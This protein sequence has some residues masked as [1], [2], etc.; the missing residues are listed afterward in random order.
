MAM[1]LTSPVSSGN[2]AP[3]R[4]R[5]SLAVAGL[6]F[7][8][9]A[10]FRMGAQGGDFIRGD[11]NG[12]GAVDIGD[13]IALLGFLF[14]N[15]EAADCL[16]ALDANDSGEVDIAD[17]VS[18]LGYLF[19]D[20]APPPPP[21]PLRCGPDP[22]DDALACASHAACPAA[23]P[24][25]V[26][27]SAQSAGTPAAW[28]PH[29]AQAGV[30]WARL[31]P[32][33]GNIQPS[34]G[35][36]D[37][38]SVDA[39]L[40]TAA[41]NN[42]T[43]SGLFFYNV[44][45]LAADTHTFPM[46]NLDAWSTYVSRLVSHAGKSVTYWEVWNEPQGF[47]AGGTFADYAQVVIRAYDA[48]KAAD[49]AV[50]IGLS[51]AA[52]DVNYLQQTIKTGAAGHFDFVAVHP[53]E[54]T[55][56]LEKGWEPVFMSIV[57]GV[58]RMLAA[59]DTPRADVPVWFTELGRS[60]A[61][62]AEA[63]ARQ[64]HALVKAF[65]MAVAQGVTRV[66]WYEARDGQGG[67]GLL[68]GTGVR[69]AAYTALSSLTAHLGSVPD[70]R[71]WVQLNAGRDYGF[72]FQGPGTAV[73]PLW[74]A[75]GTTENVTFGAAVRVLDPATGGVT[76]LSA[77]SPLALTNAPVLILDVPSSLVARA[78]DNRS[79]AFPWGG[80]YTGAASIS[81]VMGDPNTEQG[82]H[83]LD[84][85][86]S[87]TPVE[88][89]GAAARDASKSSSQQFT[90]D[91]NFLCYTP[92]RIEITAVTRR[93]AAND[94]AGFN[95]KYESQTGWKTA[96][97]WYTVPGNTEWYTHTWTITD[98]QFVSIWGYNFRFDSDS[99]AHSRYY[100][101]QVTVTKAGGSR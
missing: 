75:A 9:A 67:F 23:S 100:I 87:S 18:M 99:T 5:R 6:V 47:A 44:R 7:A 77:G 53:Y 2:P 59:N 20:G 63:D 81:V 27:S 79:R 89:Y 38:A 85:D 35:T 83:Q 69:R 42:I 73:M 93:N 19:A 48:A 78:Q 25:G 32:E 4:R 62:S 29:M 36:W 86:S 49:P 58:R 71:G 34:A 91:P 24:F 84:P 94:N 70:F 22:T 50:Q 95:L 54:I 10:A 30:A 40:G 65:T 98:D 16:D 52:N 3:K 46:S 15:V 13:P 64:A 45:W 11:A 76:N 55:E 31:F 68:S 21:G 80:D 17:A 12:D 60:S 33:W 37:W 39:L 88:V 101:R 90:V 43:V 56:A 41:T 1:N 74:A 72:V 8:V 61:G 92:A 82:L 66:N 51:V 14:S 28:M 57:K 96:G 26:A 97:G